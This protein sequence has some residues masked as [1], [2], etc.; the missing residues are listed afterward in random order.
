MHWQHVIVGDFIHV[1]LDEVIPADIL[2]IRS[3]DPDGVCFVETS[4]LDGETSLKQRRVPA[5]MILYSGVSLLC[6]MKILLIGLAVVK[7]EECSRNGNF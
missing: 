3:S 2:L 1:S 6:R 4:N 7:S 5:S